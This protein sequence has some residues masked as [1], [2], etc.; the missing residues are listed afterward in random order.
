M[1]RKWNKKLDHV[2]KDSTAWELGFRLLSGSSL[3]ACSKAASREWSKCSQ[4]SCPVK[5]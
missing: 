3:S 5:T 1:V 4:K 2:I